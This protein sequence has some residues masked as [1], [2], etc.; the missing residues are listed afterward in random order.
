MSCLFIYLFLCLAL[1]G[2]RHYMQAFSTCGEQGLLSS[3]H[4]WASHC[5]GFSCCRAWALKLQVGSCAHWF[6]HFST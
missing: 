3:R 4:T 6:L 5:S 1:L 2:L